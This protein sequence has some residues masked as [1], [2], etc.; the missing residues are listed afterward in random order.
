MGRM[1][2]EKMNAELYLVTREKRRNEGRLAEKEKEKE[3]EGLEINLR[4]KSGTTLCVE[5]SFIYT[6]LNSP[7]P[8]LFLSCLFY[9]RYILF[10]FLV[11]FYFYFF[12]NR[13]ENIFIT[14]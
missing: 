10:L 8:L 6:T 1:E 3:R 5:T 4:D 2:M 11:P 7:T 12:I 13:I 14:L 9:K